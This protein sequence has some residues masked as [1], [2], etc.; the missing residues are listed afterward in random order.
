MHRT[1]VLRL[2]NKYGKGGRVI[3]MVEGR[4]YERKKERC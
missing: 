3:E 1:K 2:E 4:N